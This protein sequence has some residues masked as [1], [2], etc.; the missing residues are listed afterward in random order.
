MSSMMKPMSGSAEPPESTSYLSSR[1]VTASSSSTTSRVYEKYTY[2]ETAEV[3]LALTLI[4]CRWRRDDGLRVQ[5]SSS[6]PPQPWHFR[7]SEPR[8]DASVSDQAPESAPP[9]TFEWVV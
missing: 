5:Q 8:L 4:P 1:N 9:N 3:G 2:S 7:S 6:P